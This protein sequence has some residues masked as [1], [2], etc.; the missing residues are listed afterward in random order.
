M[1]CSALDAAI[2]QP[3]TEVVKWT[4]EKDTNVNLRDRGKRSEPNVIGNHVTSCEQK[5]APGEEL[6]SSV[7]L[8]V[9]KWI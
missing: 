9:R 7:G 4:S 8:P 1:A 2:L 6:R 5:C 3:E